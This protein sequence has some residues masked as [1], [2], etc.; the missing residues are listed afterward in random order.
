LISTEGPGS[1]FVAFFVLSISTRQNP[2]TADER[3]RSCRSS[4]RKRRRSI[5]QAVSTAF[6]SCRNLMASQLPFHSRRVSPDV[7]IELEEIKNVFCNEV[8]KREVIDG[9]QADLERKKIARAA[10][11]SSPT[12]SA[13][14]VGAEA[15]SRSWIARGERAS[16][17]MR[18]ATTGSVSLC[19]RMKS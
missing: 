9:E 6:S 5:H 10:S 7:R 13:K 8:L 1:I 4:R 11:K 12:I 15:A 18:T 16:L 2:G 14:P 3:K 19:T 17:R